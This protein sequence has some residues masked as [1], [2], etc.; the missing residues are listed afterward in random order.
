MNTRHIS[1]YHEGYRMLN[2]TATINVLPMHVTCHKPFTIR[3]TLRYKDRLSKYMDSR[4]KD[5]KVMRPFYLNNHHSENDTR[6]HKLV[7][8]RRPI[9]GPIAVTSWWG[10]C[11]LKSPGPRLFTQPSGADQR[12]HQSSTSLAFARGIHRWPVNSPHEGPVT[13]KMF[14]FDDVIMRIYVHHLPI[15]SGLPME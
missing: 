12:K 3:G 10:R 6:L 13:W 1:V 11:R 14:P 2:D 4:Y 15:W 5:N 9:S 8:Q 7:Y